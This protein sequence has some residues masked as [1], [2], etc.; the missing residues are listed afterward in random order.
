MQHPRVEWLPELDLT[1]TET[2]AVMTLM[3]GFIAPDSGLLHRA[4]SGLRRRTL[5]ALQMADADAVFSDGARAQRPGALRAATL[6]SAFPPG[7]PLRQAWGAL[8]W[9]V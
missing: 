8:R 5:R 9:G 6:K 7:M 4:A 2:L 3:D 1:L